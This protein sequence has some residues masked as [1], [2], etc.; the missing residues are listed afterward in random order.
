V[1]FTSASWSIAFAFACAAARICASFGRF[2]AR[3]EAALSHASFAF[4]SCSRAS[5]RSGRRRT[6]SSSSASCAGISDAS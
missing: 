5:R 1:S 3:P 4:A 6:T 2:S